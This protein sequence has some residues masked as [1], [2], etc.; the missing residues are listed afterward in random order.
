MI[1]WSPLRSPYEC[2]DSI[3]VVF[4][5]T[6]LFVKRDDDKGSGGYTYIFPQFPMALTIAMDAARFAGGR[7]I[8]LAV[9]AKVKAKP[10][11]L[12]FR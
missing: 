4:V 6:Y 8:V 3:V 5:R 2:A 7:G 10:S 11:N 1:A 12:G 9:H